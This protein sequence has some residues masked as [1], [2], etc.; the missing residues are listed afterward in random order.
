MVLRKALNTL[1]GGGVVLLIVGVIMFVAGVFVL[2]GMN[3][4]IF[5]P[6]LERYL[7][8]QTGLRTQLGS[9]RI[10]GGIPFKIRC[11]N[12]AFFH[13]QSKEKLMES[14]DVALKVDPFA[15]DRPRF[16]MPQ[17][18]IRN[19]EVLLRRDRDGNWNWQISKSNPALKDLGAPAGVALSQKVAGE[20]TAAGRIVPSPEEIKGSWGSQDWDFGNGDVTF[21]NG[22]FLFEDEGVQPALRVEAEKLEVVLN[23][24]ADAFVFDFKMKAVLREPFPKDI[25]FEGTYDVNSRFSKFVLS[26]GPE[27]FVFRGTFK[28]AAVPQVGGTIRAQNL[29]MASVTP[30]AYK[31][32]EYLQ[33][34][35]NGTFFFSFEGAQ[36]DEIQS[37]LRGGGEI[38][39]RDGALKNRN[40][41]KE[42]MERLSPVLTVANA[43]GG[44]L[45]PEIAAMMKGQDTS[46][47]SL[48]FSCAVDQGVAKVRNFSLTHTSY[49][50]KGEGNYTFR[51]SYVDSVLH[52]TMSQ[53][54]SAYF[55]GKVAE[56]KF[57][58]DPEGC[59]GIPFVYAGTVGGA[60]AQP[61]LPYIA[62]KVFQAGA[63]Q[64]VNR[65]VEKLL[66]HIG[67]RL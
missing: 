42:I 18:L 2:K 17:V 11:S 61:D 23:R 50:L 37:S 33:G 41:V 14:D 58:S 1:I 53:A 35:L 52:L 63:E 6:H 45:P 30:S 48:K 34:L 49:Q 46:F 38:E 22:R 64:L 13:P 39:I 44:E 16:W 65:G 7:S 54:V 40:L 5:R 19:F 59:V 32:D 51:N 20:E 67:A 66:K 47:R 10:D 25:R 28:M 62:A 3:P 21:R 57:L 29:E 12:L 26:C 15:F 4:E 24:R 9:I 27:E 56:L 60:Q 36:R 55:I 8:E 43:L 31:Q